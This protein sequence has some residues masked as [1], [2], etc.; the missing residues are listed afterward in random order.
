MNIQTSSFP[1]LRVR[2]LIKKDGHLLDARTPD[3]GA[4]F[5]PGGRVE[6]GESLEAALCREILEETGAKIDS[7][8]YLGSVENVWLSNSRPVHD[9]NH[10]F[11]VECSTLSISNTPQC[12]DEG[13]ELFWMPVKNIEQSSIRPRIVKKFINQTLQGQKEP[14]WAFIDEVSD[15]LKLKVMKTRDSVIKIKNVSISN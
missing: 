11:L 14:W 12:V 5:L 2:A 9:L 3:D 10:F 15:I 1:I 13:V 4:E 7:F 6:T 8:L